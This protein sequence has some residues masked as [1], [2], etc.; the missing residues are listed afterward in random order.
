MDTSKRKRL[1]IMTPIG[2]FVEVTIATEIGKIGA[3]TD[4]QQCARQGQQE[5][6][7]GFVKEPTAVRAS[8]RIDCK[9]SIGAC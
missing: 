1:G 7:L 4:N 8:A 3:T 6:T 5:L 2:L 9:L